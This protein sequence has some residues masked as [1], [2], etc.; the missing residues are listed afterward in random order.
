[1]T[2]ALCMMY[3]IPVFG[4][5]FTLTFRLFSSRQFTTHASLVNSL[6]Q[7]GHGSPFWKNEVKGLT[8]ASDLKLTELVAKPTSA[9]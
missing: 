1:M 4:A 7:S 8:F 6:V 9:A 3:F 5:S 2:A